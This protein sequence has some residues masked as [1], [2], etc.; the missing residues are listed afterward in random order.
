MTYM[1]ENVDFS[2]SAW[3]SIIFRCLSTYPCKRYQNK[4]KLQRD[5]QAAKHL[6]NRA[7]QWM[8]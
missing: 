8:V 6:H 3:N 1:L 5:D 4:I 7:I 2:L